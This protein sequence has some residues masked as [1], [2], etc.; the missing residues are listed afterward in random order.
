MAWR[1]VIRHLER[2]RGRGRGLLLLDAKKLT[3][4]QPPSPGMSPV[5][6][7]QGK[8]MEGDRSS[9]RLWSWILFL[10]VCLY[11]N[12]FPTIAPGRLAS[13]DKFL[14][15]LPLI[16]VCPQD[17]LDTW[18]QTCQCSTVKTYQIKCLKTFINFPVLRILQ[19]NY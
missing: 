19:H 7:P 12:S 17:L 11:L 9:L 8:N 16:P 10:S 6:S 3:S 15:F 4:G 13:Q 18:G 5:R 14:V 2:S 1:R